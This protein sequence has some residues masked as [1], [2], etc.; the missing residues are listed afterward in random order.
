[1]DLYYY[2]AG[3]LILSELAFLCQMLVNFRYFFK[4]SLKK[5]T[6][7]RPRTAVLVPCKGI[8]AEFELNITSL[9]KQDFDNY[10]L[11]FIVGDNSDPAYEFL[12]R[13]KDRLQ[14]SS[15]AC[16]V[17]ILVAGAATNSGQKI[18]N[19]LHACNQLP[20]DV[21]AIAFA[22]SDACFRPDWLI[23]LLH[24][25]R[26]ERTGVSTGYRWF[27]PQ[28][29]NLATL[30]LAGLNGKI[31]QLLGAYRFNQAWGGSMAVRTEVFKKL[32]VAKVWSTAVSDDL[33]LSYLVKKAKMKIAYVPACLVPSYDQTTW[34]RLFEFA[35]RQFVI[36]RIAMPGTW[37][38]GFL[39]TIYSVAGLFGSAIAAA[40]AYSRPGVYF[41]IYIAVP[42]V[43]MV[44]H[45]ILAFLRQ[46]M[47]FRLLPAERTRLVPSAIADILGSW[48]LSVILLI[49]I[50]SSLF[51]RKIVWR[52]ITYRLVGPTSTIIEK[53][54]DQP[55]PSKV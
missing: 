30:A 55:V 1:M 54:P 20:E 48:L 16:D 3:A 17:R 8:D 11:W 32:D 37:W 51:G 44:N 49:T 25:L 23:Q 40:I 39:G 38:F 29:N 22:D 12:C 14:G 10:I 13:L 34:P 28:K 21:E 46:T 2:L 33:S 42:I 53:S 15:E 26:Q 27:V 52:G 18:H 43:F 31:A 35:R 7:Y 6:A 19:L 41:S 24:P 47:I 9:Y 50:T 45:M 4:K 5:R 36:T